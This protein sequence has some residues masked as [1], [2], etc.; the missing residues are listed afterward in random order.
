[1]LIGKFGGRVYRHFKKRVH[2]I[3]PGDELSVQKFSEEGFKSD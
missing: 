1:L 3:H 2:A